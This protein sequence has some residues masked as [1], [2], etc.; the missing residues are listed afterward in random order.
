MNQA[1][2]PLEVESVYKIPKCF[3]VKKSS[4]ISKRFQLH[5][6]LKHTFSLQV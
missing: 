3:Q 4:K 1:D 2:T 5:N 6:N